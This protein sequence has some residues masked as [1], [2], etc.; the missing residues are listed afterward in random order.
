VAATSSWAL[1]FARC[2]S[3][4]RKKQ[5][6]Q[7]LAMLRADME[8]MQL[9]PSTLRRAECTLFTQPELIDLQQ[10][11]FSLIPSRNEIV[12]TREGQRKTKLRLRK[13]KGVS[14]NDEKEIQLKRAMH[15]V[16]HGELPP[17]PQSADMDGCD[18]GTSDANS[19]DAS[20]NEE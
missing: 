6:D 10:S 12:V 5:I 15:Y 11:G 17:L 14:L 7:L 13:R 3:R 19:N 9:R 18:G 16:E 4:L 8:S 20:N 1:R 2:S